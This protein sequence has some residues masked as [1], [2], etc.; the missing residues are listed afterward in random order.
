MK[1][2]RLI[3]DL[4]NTITDD[5]K[6]LDYQK[7]P[8]NNQVRQ[9]ILESSEEFDIT[10]FTARNMKSLEGDLNRIHQITKPI[11]IKWLE[12][13]EVRYDDIIFGKPYC[14]EE[15]HYVDDK[16]IS[17]EEFVFKFS[18]PFRNTPIDIV[19]PFYNEEENILD[20]YKDLKKLERLFHIQKYIFIN[21]GSIDESDRLFKELI[22]IDKKIELVDVKKNI[23]LGNG[24]KQGIQKSTAEFILLNHSDRQFDAYTYFLTHIEGLFKIKDPSSIF[25]LRKNRPLSHSF[26]TYFLRLTLGIL[27]LK[28]IKDFNGQPKLI[29]RKL[30]TDIEKLPNNYTIDFII[31]KM[32]N[33]KYFFPII[34]K[35]RDKGVSSWSRNIF[36]KLKIFSTYILAS[37]K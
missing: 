19:V 37:L 4:D 16:N 18:G 2:N 27:S 21:N 32:V 20:V 17:I 7:K 31:Y 8:L 10:I 14:G 23:G 33:P 35:P 26:F 22:N 6:S 12:E 25:S 28:K 1:K 3:I 24:I 13:N 9:S 5:D 15:G 29:E 36:G 30:V 34:E 11:A